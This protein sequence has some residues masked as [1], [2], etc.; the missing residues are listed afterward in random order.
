MACLMIEEWRDDR[1]KR[2]NT[3]SNSKLLEPA[4]VFEKSFLH[5]SLISTKQ[6]FS[7]KIQEILRIGSLKRNLL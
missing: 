7:L 4:L 3:W 2:L 1:F 6:H 5:E